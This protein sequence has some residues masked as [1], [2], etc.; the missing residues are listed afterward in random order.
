MPLWGGF[1]IGVESSEPK[2]AAVGDR[3]GAALEV[4]DGDR[5]L[6]G[7]GGEVGDRLLDRGERAAGR[8]R[9]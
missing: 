8:R 9:G 4:G 7:L 2:I 3:E 6:A 5:P 1:R